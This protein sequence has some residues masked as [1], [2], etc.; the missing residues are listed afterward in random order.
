MQLFRHY[1][2]SKL[3][4]L[5]REY[6]EVV[7]AVVS[8]LRSGFRRDDLL[9]A[10][11]HGEIQKEGKIGE[12]EFSFRDCRLELLRLVPCELLEVQ[13]HRLQQLGYRLQMA[14]SGNGAADG[15]APEAKLALD[16]FGWTTN[17]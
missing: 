10:R 13:R 14:A 7:Q 12:L 11:R 5:I 8:A 6:Q 9:S 3:R 4:L 16:A 2:G 17:D 15:S 1:K